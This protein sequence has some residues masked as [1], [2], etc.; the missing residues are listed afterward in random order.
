MQDKLER[1]YQ[2]PMLGYTYII[3]SSNVGQSSYLHIQLN[4]IGHVVRP[5]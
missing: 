2:S 4:S 5:W 1:F 3:R